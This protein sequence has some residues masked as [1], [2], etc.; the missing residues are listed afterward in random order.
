[1]LEDLGHFFSFT[2]ELRSNPLDWI[3]GYFNFDFTLLPKTFSF[4][5]RG[6]SPIYLPSGTSLMPSFRP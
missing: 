1:M 6:I 2:D 3:N 5:V 4:S